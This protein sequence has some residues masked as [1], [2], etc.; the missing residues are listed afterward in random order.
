[1]KEI[2]LQWLKTAYE[3]KQDDELYIPCVN[4]KEQ[5]DIIKLLITMHKNLQKADPLATPGLN[6][7][8]TFKDHK[9]WV[10]ITRASSIPTTAYIKN[11][12]TGTI[13]RIELEQENNRSRR[14]DLMHKDGLSI[15]EVEEI[16]GK[17]SKEEKAI[18]EEES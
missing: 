9:Q 3:M 17:L 14:I 12:T 5:R 18:W 13:S 8:G 1:M 11:R 16:E 10:L 2:Y 15:S 6:I 7:H 4:R